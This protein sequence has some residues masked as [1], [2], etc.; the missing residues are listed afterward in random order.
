MVMVVP[1]LFVSP[2]LFHSVVVENEKFNLL[3]RQCMRSNQDD[4]D[5]K[6]GD[7]LVQNKN[8]RP[9][10]PTVNNDLEY[11]IDND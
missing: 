1:L 7:T 4:D 8:V 11:V 3:L 10:V 2:S 6:V 9:P 5:E